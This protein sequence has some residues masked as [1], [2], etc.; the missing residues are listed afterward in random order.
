ML[1]IYFSPSAENRLESRSGKG[2]MAGVAVDTVIAVE[3]LFAG[4]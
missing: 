3:E 1:A 2:V 4:R